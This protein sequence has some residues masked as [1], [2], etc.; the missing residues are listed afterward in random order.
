[1]KRIFAVVLILTATAPSAAHAQTLTVYSSLP[2]SGGSARSTKAINHGARLALQQS[3]NADVRLVTLDSATAKTG[4]WAPSRV[5][6]N[7]L[8]AAQDKSTIAF[9]GEYYSG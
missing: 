9:I 8:R 6:D 2:L 3:G 7:A 5:A 4:T 1:M